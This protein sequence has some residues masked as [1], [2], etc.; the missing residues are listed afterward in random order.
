MKRVS[1]LPQPTPVV[2]WKRGTWP[3]PDTV[4]ERLKNF[5]VDANGCHVWGGRCDGGY[6]RMTVRGK[7]WRVHRL[8]YIQHVDRLPENMVVRQR[9]GNRLCINPAHLY[10]HP[11]RKLTAAQVA[12]IRRRYGTTPTTQRELAD[13][14]G[15]ST[16][17][18]FVVLHPELGRAYAEVPTDRGVR[19]RPPVTLNYLTT[20]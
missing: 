6:G 14:F 18:M 4:S 1:E 10:L 20:L 17:H 5:T 19:H 8:A 9:C 15:L 3:R 16:G 11:K 12:D 7:N 2:R 13:E